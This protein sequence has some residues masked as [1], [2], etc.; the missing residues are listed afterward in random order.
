MRIFRAFLSVNG[1]NTVRKFT[2][3]RAEDLRILLRRIVF[4]QFIAKRDG[5]N[6]NQAFFCLGRGNV[7]VAGSTGVLGITNDGRD[8]GNVASVFVVGHITYT[9][10]RARRNHAGNSALGTFRVGVFRCRPF[11]AMCNNTTGRR[12]HCRRLF[13]HRHCCTFF[14]AGS[15]GQRGSLG[16]TDPVGDADEVR[17][18]QWRGS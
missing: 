11:D 10:Q 16:D 12:Q 4:R 13:R 5:T 18:V 8:T 17:P 14:L 3:A 1:N 6:G 7:A 2:R 15:R 9:R